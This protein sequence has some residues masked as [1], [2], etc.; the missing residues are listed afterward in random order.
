MA[1]AADGELAMTLV[2]QT[3]V[4]VRLTNDQSWRLEALVGTLDEVETIL[5]KDEHVE[6][7]RV[8]SFRQIN[9]L[10]TA[11]PDYRS[12]HC[13]GWLWD[14]PANCWRPEEEL[15]T[16]PP[17]SPASGEL[18]LALGRVRFGW[19]S[20]DIRTSDATMEVTFDDVQDSFVPVVRFVSLLIVGRH[21]HF[22]AL[23][24]EHPAALATFPAQEPGF[25]RLIA[26]RLSQRSLQ[27]DLDVLVD[28]Q[29][30]I[31]KFRTFLAALADHPCF[32]PMWLCHAGL[33]SEPYDTISDEADQL[34]ER[35]VHEGR[36][37]DDWDAGEDFRA[38][39]ISKRVP[40]LPESVAYIDQYRAM[41]RTL[42]IPPTWD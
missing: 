9:S 2:P 30:L 25:C 10:S 24:T 34:W 29:A 18:N 17:G 5:A 41:L 35:G 6:E 27:P 20:L 38:A 26:G 28:R 15:I 3:T 8:I 42:K 36:W 13:R 31:G 19:I 33:L 4:A 37:E 32:G 23:G 1:D 22:G 14:E 7:F 16:P 12:A 40:L 11:H 39:Y 21:P